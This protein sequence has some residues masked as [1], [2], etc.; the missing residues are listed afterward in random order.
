MYL[1]ALFVRTYINGWRVAEAFLQRI[2]N[3]LQQ[4]AASLLS[5]SSLMAGGGEV[6]GLGLYPSLAFD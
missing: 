4:P 1:S 2:Q 5:P 6:L 3:I